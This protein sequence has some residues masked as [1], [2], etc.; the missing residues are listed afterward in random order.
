MFVNKI[1]NASL[2]RYLYDLTLSSIISNTYKSNKLM[3]MK[4]IKVAIL[5]TF[6]GLASLQAQQSLIYTSDNAEFSKAL[7]LY[8]DKSYQASQIIFEKVKNNTDD[9]EIQSDCAYYIANCAIRLE[10][11]GADDLMED[12]VKDYPTSTRRNKAYLEVGEYYFQIGDY[13]SS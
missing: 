7:M 10:Q 4:K 9:T 13:S 12:F 5:M 2:I 1:L 3:N 6:A 11:L 8:K